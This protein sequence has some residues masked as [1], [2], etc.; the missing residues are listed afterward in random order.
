M[1]T[2]KVNKALAQKVLSV[3]DKGLV[4]GLGDPEPGKMCVEAA[5]NYALGLPHGDQ[6]KC[7]GSNVREFK[8][9]L[10]DSYWPTDKDRT[11]GMRRLA[12]AQLG[13]D[14]LDQDEFLTKV[15]Y[16]CMTTVLPVMVKNSINEDKDNEFFK[17]HVNVKKLKLAVK[18]LESARDFDS[19][20]EATGKVRDIYF[21]SAYASAYAYASASASASASDFAYASAYAYASASAFASAFAFAFASASASDFAFAPASAFAS[22][23]AFAFASSFA[24]APASAS[25]FAQKMPRFSL[26]ILNLIAQAGLDTLIEMKSPG[27]RYLGLC[28][29]NQSK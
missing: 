23:F 8:I 15:G 26:K 3:V 17:K 6:P 29:L 18:K 21:A 20:K 14:T 16:R 4:K 22:A 19:A 2:I 1:Q 10:N 7:V 11:K 24:F 13:S 28:E 25:A 9:A 27:V 5:V 12:V